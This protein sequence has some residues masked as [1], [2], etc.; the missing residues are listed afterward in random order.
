MKRLASLATRWLL[1]VTCLTLATAVTQAMAGAQSTVRMRATLNAKQQVPPQVVK[2]PSASG[3]F[4]A[5]LRR[6]RGGKSQLEWQLSYRRL[7]SR[8]TLAY[9]RLPA[10]RKQGEVVVQ[11]CKGRHCKTKVEGTVRLPAVVAKALSGRTGYVT[12]RTKKNPKGEISGR[13]RR[14]G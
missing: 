9:V 2:A 12:I 4:S 10:N 8:A 11:L 14:T 6:K 1:I 3:S 5:T 7:S 13:I